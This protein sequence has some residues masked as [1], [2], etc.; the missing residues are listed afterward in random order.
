MVQQVRPRQAAVG[1]LGE[2]P[3]QEGGELARHVRRE[4]HVLVHDLVHERVDVLREEGRLAAE[5]LVQDDAERP[6][7]RRVVVRLLLH[8]LGR[9]VQRRA[10]D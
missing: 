4:G 10:L 9:H 2:E 7:V 8:Q 1:P 6:Q 3:A 5:E